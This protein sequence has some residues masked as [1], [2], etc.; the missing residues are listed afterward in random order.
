MPD[1]S[2]NI[3]SLVIVDETQRDAAIALNDELITVDPRLI[4]NPYADN[5]GYGTLYGKYAFSRN[6]LISQEYSR[7]W[8]MLSGCLI[9]IADTDFLF[10]VPQDPIQ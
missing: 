6:V 3:T 4:N 8:E 1:S 9:I 10:S 2:A 5:L 7:W